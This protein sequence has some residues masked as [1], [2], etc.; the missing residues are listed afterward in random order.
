[1]SKGHEKYYERHEQRRSVLEKLYE[2][3]IHG[4][5]YQSPMEAPFANALLK[6]V[7]ANIDA[8]DTIIGEHLFGYTLKRL[9]TV[10]RAILRIAT[11]ELE[12]T[13]TPSE[14]II[15][16]ALE[17][18]HVFSDEGDRKHVSFNNRVLENIKK[19]LREA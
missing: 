16:E 1:M 2:M 17:L 4:T 12:Y 3:D 6:G 8:I 18:T 13:G 7:T 9:N 15:D 19:T 5:F 10:D 11:Y 14:I